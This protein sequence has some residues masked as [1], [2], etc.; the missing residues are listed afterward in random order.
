MLLGLPET[1]DAADVF[2]VIL[3]EVTPHVI[4]INISSIGIIRRVD[5]DTFDL[6]GVFRFQ[7]FQRKQI[8]PMNQHIP[9]IGFPMI[10]AGVM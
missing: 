3:C 5:I 2:G 8:I 10:P 1:H 7:R 6:S 4:L 9:G